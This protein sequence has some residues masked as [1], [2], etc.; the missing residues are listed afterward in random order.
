MPCREHRAGGV[1][2]ADP[3]G[4]RHRT[5][6]RR[7]DERKDDYGHSALRSRPAS[8]DAAAGSAITIPAMITTHPDHPRAPSRS[9]AIV[10]PK[11]AV[12]TGS[13]ENARAVCVAV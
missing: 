3:H 13:S 6:E 9:P 7:G 12:H 5:E 2:E 11:N 1:G 8:T 4:N 10:N